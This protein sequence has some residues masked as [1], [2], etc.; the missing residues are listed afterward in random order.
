MRFLW[1][2]WLKRCGQDLIEYALLAGFVATAAAAILPHVANGIS[3]I[4]TKAASV[5]DEASETGH[6]S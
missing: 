1:K 5:V 6:G 4:M 2:L 3:T